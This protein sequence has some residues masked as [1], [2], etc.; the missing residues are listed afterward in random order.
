MA[1][2]AIIAWPL[3]ADI[4]LQ[5][6]RRIAFENLRLYIEQLQ[7]MAMK[8]VQ[9]EEEPETGRFRDEVIAVQFV[10]IGPGVRWATGLEGTLG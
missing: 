8:R 4:E 6:T 3:L 9:V 2:S 10:Q 5:R 1:A 7:G